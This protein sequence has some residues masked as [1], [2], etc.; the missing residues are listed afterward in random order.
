ME[1][2]FDKDYDEKRK[3]DP[4]NENDE[5]TDLTISD[6]I[7]NITEQPLDVK[8]SKPENEQ[9]MDMDPN[10]KVEKQVPEDTPSPS[11]VNTKDNDPEI[12]A[13][14]ADDL[15]NSGT[16]QP[17]M[18]E[19]EEKDDLGSDEGI[20]D[21]DDNEVE[22][23]VDSENANKDS[24][25]APDSPSIDPKDSTSDRREFDCEELPC[26]ELDTTSE[27]IPLKCSFRDGL[28]PRKVYLV[29]EAKLMG[30]N[31]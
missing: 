19:D 8:T 27:E 12:D 4:T 18:I 7:E 23:A 25:M 28:K 15:D 6:G 1:N 11:E 21:A 5:S 13:K 24:I 3:Q 10:V 30:E 17:D 16:D 29:I 31:S 14:K 22:K 9:N 20:T 26:G 2:D